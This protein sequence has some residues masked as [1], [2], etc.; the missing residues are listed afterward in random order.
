LPCRGP[1]E[2]RELVER[3]FGHYNS[4]LEHTFNMIRSLS[5]I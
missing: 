2:R 1:P 4:L 3:G 5:T